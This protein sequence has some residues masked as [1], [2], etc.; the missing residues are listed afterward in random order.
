MLHW[1]KGT[2]TKELYGHL[3]IIPF[4]NFL[5]PVNFHGK[6]IGNHMTGLY[7]N[8][9]YNEVCYKGTILYWSFHIVHVSNCWCN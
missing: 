5:L 3:T 1:N 2:I 7:T 9:C 6:K 8:L 4:A